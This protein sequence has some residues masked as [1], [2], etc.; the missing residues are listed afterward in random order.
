MH[1]H[2]NMIS[3][4]NKN[5]ANIVLFTVLIF[6]LIGTSFTTIPK[7]KLTIEE[8]VDSLLSLMTLDEKIGQM[9]QVRHF[10]DISEDDIS[11]KFIGS[12]IHTQGPIP[13][14]TVDDW[15]SKFRDLQNQALSTRLGI[16]L[17]FGV[18]AVHG[19]NTFEGAT[20]F[21]HN[22]GMGASGNP[23]MVMKS[24]EITAIEMHATGLNWTFSPCVAIPYNE[25]WGR[26]Y[27][28]FSESTPLTCEL[29]YAA[30]KGYQSDF[31]TSHSVLATAKHFI[32]DGATDYGIEGGNTSLSAEEINNR[33]LPPYKAAVDA[34]VGAIMVSFNSVLGSNM[35][36]HKALITDT[37]KRGMGFDGIV[38]TDWKGFSR[39]GGINVINAGVD[40]VMA[41]DG[42]MHYFQSKLKESVIQDSVSMERINDAVKRILRQKYRMGLFDNPFPDSSLSIKLG[43]DEHRKIAKQAVRES[44]VLLKNENKTLPL[45]KETKKIVV[46]GEHAN[47]SG[48][49]SGGW[50]V[51]WRGTANNYKGAT[52][53]LEGIQK[54][55]YGDVVYDTLA[56]GLVRDADI[57]IIVVG[58]NP[59]V[60]FFGDIGDGTGE[61]TLDLKKE[62]KDYIDS[63]VDIGIPTV[64]ILI[65]GRPMIITDELNKTDA[66][67]VGWLPGSEGDGFAEVLFGDYN[68][69][70]KL[71]HSWPAN[72]N[73]YE[74]KYGPNYWNI[75]AN[76]LFQFGYGLAY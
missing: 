71:P 34:G 54:L 64:V 40:M 74:G 27:E 58:E 33:L 30:V 7:S 49:Q 24:A 6:L 14:E 28:A 47:N 76:P 56:D 29:T 10:Y 63:Y 23:D 73:Q 35:H 59:Y 36:A 48:L 51:N 26:V 15:Q 70:G 20:I 9:T 61:F 52:T 16:P 42:D 18:D 22:I 55:S 1:F 8:K 57:A 46:V 72:L 43:C 53:I 37:L 65:S 11:N 69:T 31:N 68:F 25:K 32:G 3:Y 19:Q 44:L 17:L 5:I 41:V 62:H 13:G 45:K 21:P 60:E 50:T 39:F 66:F 4:L 2:S 38:L 67:V 75:D 12:V